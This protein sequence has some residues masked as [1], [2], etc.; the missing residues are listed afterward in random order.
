MFYVSIC[1]CREIVKNFEKRED[2][3]R[4]EYI[5]EIKKLSVRNLTARLRV[6]RIRPGWTWHSL[7]VT[8]TSVL[9]KRGL[10]FAPHRHHAGIGR[11]ARRGARCGTLSSVSGA[12]Q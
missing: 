6:R 1:T 12:E 2:R 5:W 4:A 3:R 8:P 11:A 9:S 10:T 7:L